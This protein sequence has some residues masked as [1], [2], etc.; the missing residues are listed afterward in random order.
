[1]RI[2]GIF[3]HPVAINRAIDGN[4]I[5]NGGVGVSGSHQSLI[6][7]LEGLAALGHECVLAVT[8]GNVGK[9][10][11]GV[12]Y[13]DDKL[14]GRKNMTWDVVIILD[15]MG[16]DMPF[17]KSLLWEVKLFIVLCECVGIKS[18][19]KISEIAAHFGCRIGIVYVSEWC[20]RATRIRGIPDGSVEVVIPN[21]LM[22]DM[23]VQSEKKSRSMVFHPVFERGGLTALK[24]FYNM[25]WDDG[26]MTVFNYD[27]AEKK[28]PLHN[29]PG[30]RAKGSGDKYAIMKHLA[31]AEYFV[32]PL[33]LPDGNVHRDTFACSVAEAL[34]CEVLVVTYPIGALPELY[35]DSCFWLDL[36]EGYDPKLFDDP[37]F[38]YC[39]EMKNETAVNAI[40]AAVRR[41]ESDPQ[42]KESLRKSGKDLVLKKFDPKH[43]ASR[44]E[45]F[46]LHFKP[47]NLFFSALKFWGIVDV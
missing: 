29:L 23:L 13:T 35:G 45:R 7:I 9:K 40:C 17:Y 33:A 20:Q 15:W 27:A 12:F 16:D 6:L 42:L 8:N 11:K 38:I 46:I 37:Y 1:M 36:P 22:V 21:P 47:G 30:V 25:G 44:W 4:S 24:A 10:I 41:L 18:P 32:Y 5:R 2:L 28:T 19:H 43:I 14:I 39:K 26:Q 3:K 31:E 34:A